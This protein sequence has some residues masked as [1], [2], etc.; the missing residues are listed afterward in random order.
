MTSWWQWIELASDFAYQ[1]PSEQSNLR[2][3]ESTGTVHLFQW[4]GTSD[5]FRQL[6]DEGKDEMVWSGFVS[7]NSTPF[8]TVKFTGDNSHPIFAQAH[9]EEVM[10][11]MIEQLPDL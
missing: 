1:C 8:D 7:V 6:M 5:D 2:L 3:D 9:Y 10:S 11:V 4:P